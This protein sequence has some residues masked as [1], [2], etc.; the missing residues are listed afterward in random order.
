MMPKPSPRPPVS[1]TAPRNIFVFPAWGENNPYLNMLYLVA[2]TR[3]WVLQNAT[4]LGPFFD[5][6]GNAQPGDVIHVHWTAP[7]AQHAPDEADARLRLAQFQSRVDHARA[8]GVSVLWTIHNRVPH[9]CPYPE[10]ERA[11][12]RYLARV[13]DAVITINPLTP[14]IVSDL[15]TLDPAKIVLLRHPSYQGLYAENETRAEARDSLRL[16][17]EQRAVL[18]FGQMRRYKGLTEFFSAMEEVHRRDERVVL[19]LAGK[20]NDADLE[21]ITERVPASVPARRDHRFLPDDEVQRWFLAAD[22]VVLPFQHVLNS[23]SMF[24]CATFGRSVIVPAQRELTAEFG[25]EGWVRFY[26]HENP[27]G[28]VEAIASTVADPDPVSA[29]ALAFAASR[30]P[31]R[32]ALDFDQVLEQLT[33]V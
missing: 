7:I 15:V 12:M 2:R 25:G 16:A 6:I 5:Q 19:L 23:G 29:D 14:E 8:R 20:T 9:D 4:R 24:L 28:L 1:A 3:G 22:A 30:P 31:Y 33:Q 32:L 13:A 11:L 26:D 17:P 21:W 10:V 18:F 27:E